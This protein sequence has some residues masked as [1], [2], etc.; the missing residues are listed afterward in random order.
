MEQFLRRKLH[1][2]DYLTL[3]ALWF[4]ATAGY[5]AIWASIIYVRGM[6]D[7]FS[8]YFPVFGGLCIGIPQGLL[9]RH[10]FAA[11]RWWLWIVASGVGWVGAMSLLFFGFAVVSIG[12][13]LNGTDTTGC[14]IAFCGLAGAFFGRMQ[15]F[16]SSQTRFHTDLWAITNAFAW[17]AGAWVGG[18]VGFAIYGSITTGRSPEFNSPGEAASVAWGIFAGMLIM[19]LITG[20]GAARQVQMHSRKLPR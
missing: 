4:L 12:G 17:V 6:F 13:G 14:G 15:N 19:G 10:Y 3:W 5:G 20:L 9:L 16:N 8:F 1:Q 7:P 11:R 18:I 2:L